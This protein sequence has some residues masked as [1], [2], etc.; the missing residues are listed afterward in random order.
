MKQLFCFWI[1]TYLTRLAG[2]LTTGG[3]LEK[4]GKKAF[5]RPILRFKFAKGM[6][7][8]CQEAIHNFKRQALHAGSLGFKHPTTGEDVCRQID[9]PQDRQDLI[10]KL[11]DDNAA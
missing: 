2:C 9:I 4:S 6:S 8:A 5:M 3:Y 1:I 7:E 10:Q 11:I